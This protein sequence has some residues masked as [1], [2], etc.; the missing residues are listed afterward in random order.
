MADLKRLRETYLA[1]N[2]EVKDLE[3]VLKD[4]KSSREDVA[5]EILDSMEAQ[6]LLDM[7]DSSGA[8]FTCNPR[9]SVKMVDKAA[10]FDWLEEQGLF[11]DMAT[12]NA[13]T[14]QGFVQELDANG[15]EIPPGTE[16][17]TFTKL[18]VTNRGGTSE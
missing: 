2:A 18:N 13:R 7:R 12:I 16:I 11:K 8:L 10:S 4:K 3:V 5:S 1:L 14:W 9:V 15:E 6:G 17:S